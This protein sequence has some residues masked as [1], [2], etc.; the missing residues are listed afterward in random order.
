M[1]KGFQK[2]KNLI[3]QL[4]NVTEFKVFMVNVFSG[5]ISAKIYSILFNVNIEKPELTLLHSLI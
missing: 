1:L 4:L 3:Y 2:K 5:I